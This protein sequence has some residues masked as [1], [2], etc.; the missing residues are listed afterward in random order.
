MFIFVIIIVLALTIGAINY[1]DSDLGWHLYLGKTINESHHL[2]Q[3]F[4]GYNSFSSLQIIDHEWLLDYLIYHLEHTFGYFSFVILTFAVISLALWFIYQVAKHKSN[5]LC[6]VFITLVLILPISNFFRIFRAQFLLLLATAG[7]VYVKTFVKDWRWRYFIY[8]FIFLLGNNLHGGFLILTLIPILLELDFSR[9]QRFIILI[10]VLLLAL[11]L[12][13][14]GLEYWRLVLNYQQNT[15][16]LTHIAEWIPLYRKPYN[17]GT[18]A[19]PL[20]LFLI[21]LLFNRNW[22][23]QKLGNAILLLIFLVVSV[24]ARRMLPIF[25]ILA[26]PDASL[27]LSELFQSLRASKKF[28]YVPASIIFL[29]I[30][31][32]FTFAIFSA[33][34]FS[35]NPYTKNLDYPISALNFL[36][37]NQPQS[38]NILNY[39]AWGGFQLWTHPELKVFIDGRGPQTEISP[40]ISILEEYNKFFQKNKSLTQSK[41]DQYNITD[42]LMPASAKIEGVDNQAQNLINCLKNNPGWK[43]AY[44]DKVAIVFIR[45]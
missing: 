45:K 18:L 8:F 2:I 30:F 42:V 39:Y 24:K 33:G 12:N 35:S 11:S 41:L 5:S 44:Q 19:A 43:I 37:Q 21:L 29:V 7:L 23:K 4:V 9:W 32:Y 10:G 22:Q 36:S 28:Y 1:P 25:M 15:Y 26:A 13:P 14:Y 17:W 3:N 31:S 6:A 27:G 34:T 16:Y 40:G 38:G 20:A